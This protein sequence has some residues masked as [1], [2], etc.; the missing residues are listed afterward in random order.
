VQL[1]L[2]RV[3]IAFAACTSL[4][5]LGTW[6][7]LNSA[8]QRLEHERRLRH[9]VVAERVFDELERE[10]S[11]YLERESARPSAVYEASSDVESWAPFVIGYFTVDDAYHLV[12]REQLA[13]ERA[14]RIESALAQV[15]PNPS[16][17]PAPPTQEAP[18]AQKNKLDLRKLSP[19]KLK[20]V[21]NSPEVL[22]RLNRAQD[23]REEQAA[24]K[25][26][27]FAY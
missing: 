6:A 19:A 5:L 12:S 14:R 3:R 25:Q 2:R 21:D 23:T 9:E 18:I 16:S 13:P 7:L 27:P 26:D 1:S 11:A 10:L 20:A 15:W 22:R 4:L 24:S 17:P 8:L